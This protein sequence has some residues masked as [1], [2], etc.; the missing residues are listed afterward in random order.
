VDRF[1]FAGAGAIALFAAAVPAPAS[2]AIVTAT[3]VGTVAYGYDVLNTFRPLGTL[4][5]LPY[6]LEFIF[7]SRLGTLSL[8]P[9]AVRITGG[10]DF[11]TISP[12]ISAIATIGGVS[13]SVD[14]GKFSNN[15]VEIPPQRNMFFNSVL[16]SA[17]FSNYEQKIQIVGFARNPLA[18]LPLS[19]DTPFIYNYSQGDRNGGNFRLQHIYEPGQS[20]YIFEPETYAQ[21]N[22]SQLVVNI[23]GVPEIGTWAMMLA[24][25]GLAG[26]AA[27]RQR[28]L[29]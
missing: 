28:L 1:S 12:L 10:T 2:A 26:A 8:E 29:A 5:G 18:N 24:G 23:S 20:P 22:L 13:I 6:K 7:D 17:R 21:F 4:V 16:D 19:L 9:G 14:G 11:G 3:Y 25:F 27:R 15:F